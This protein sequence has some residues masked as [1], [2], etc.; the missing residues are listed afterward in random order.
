MKQGR[1]SLDL[2]APP[3][4]W[5]RHAGPVALAAAA[6]LLVGLGCRYGA[7]H[8]GAGALGADVLALMALTVW[9]ALAAGPLA[10]GAPDALGSLLR[11]GIL[12]DAAA[13]VLLVLGLDGATLTWGVGIRLYLLWA[14]L[15]L[16]AAGLVRL[17][18]RPTGRAAMALAAATAAFVA[19]ASLFWSPGLL[20]RLDGPARQ[21]ALTVIAWTNPL[22][23]LSQ[24]LA[25]TGFVWTEQ[26][27]LYGITRVGQ[28]YLPAPLCW[29]AAAIF[30]WALAGLAWA[31]VAGRWLWRGFWYGT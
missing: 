28:D 7:L 13:V 20:A 12:A 3:S 19:C 8:A 18:A 27:V 9:I 16:A 17:A 6:T 24:T 2:Q 29:Q 4:A 5:R 23:G 10:A 26:P 22:L 31:L 15:A 14:G 1:I 30:W 21:A 25:A 11:A